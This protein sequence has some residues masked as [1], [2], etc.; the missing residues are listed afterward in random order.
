VAVD[1]KNEEEAITVNEYDDNEIED[2]DGLEDQSDH[3]CMR[4]YFMLNVLS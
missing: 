1:K 2:E 3:I 4:S